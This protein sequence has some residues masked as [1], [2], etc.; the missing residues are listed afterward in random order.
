MPF[1][2]IACSLD[3]IVDL[4][5]I[6]VSDVE[7]SNHAAEDSHYIAKVFFSTY[8]QY[9]TPTELLV[10]FRDRGAKSRHNGYQRLITRWLGEYPEDILYIIEHNKEEL[11][12]DENSSGEGS[13]SSRETTCCSL[14]ANS[15]LIGIDLEIR[16]LPMTSILG[17]F[18]LGTCLH[19]DA[20]EP[21]TPDLIHTDHQDLIK[22][23]AHTVS[24]SPVCPSKEHY[25][26]LTVLE[27]D[28]RFV[29]QQLNTMDIENLILL[30]PHTIL[31][32]TKSDPS[33]RAIVR[34]F[35]LLS[36]HVSLSIL[37]SNQ[38]LNAAI[39]WISVCIGLK[40][41]NNFNSMKAIIAGL[42]NESV[43]RLR[44]NVWAR[45]K[46]SL[47]VTF[48][49]LALEVDDNNNQSSLRQAQLD[50]IKHD[51][52]PAIPYLGIYLTDLNFIN[53]RHSKYISCGSIG[54]TNQGKLINLERCMKQYEVVQIIQLFQE[55]QINN[56]VHKR[57][58]ELNPG[59]G[60]HHVCRVVPHTSQ[61]FKKWFFN[62]QVMLTT[63]K[64]W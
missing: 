15:K 49:A 7:E 53:A 6:A 14:D 46:P 38:P 26:A 57:T 29:A 11:S 54:T 1:S 56:L 27:M 23:M 55:R 3:H 13:V 18:P 43:Y 31:E 48:E 45:L 8:R 41:L 5:L 60:M 61:L 25:Q 42:T 33:M 63:D 51:S 39:H 24:S 37:R 16:R 19:S 4:L 21:S 32:S 40:R 58:V 50:L 62:Q 17:A 35:N 47:R 44:L 20:R 59:K 22:R 52:K 30:R 28:S 34:N 36:R 2:L 9:V 10:R 64:D 12:S